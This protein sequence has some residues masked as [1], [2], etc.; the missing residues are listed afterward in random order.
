MP[1]Q[2]E[3]LSFPAGPEALRA[4][5]AAVAVAAPQAPM[6]PEP[7]A[8]PAPAPAGA[9]VVVPAAAP[10]ALAPRRIPVWPVEITPPAQEAAP[11]ETQGALVPTAVAVAAAREISARR[12]LAGMEWTS[13]QMPALAVAA[14]VAVG[15]VI[16]EMLVPAEITVVAAVAGGVMPHQLTEMAPMVYVSSL[17]FLEVAVKI[18]RIFLLRCLIFAPDSCENCASIR[19]ERRWCIQLQHSGLDYFIRRMVSG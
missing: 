7:P 16:S 1:P 13:H 9:A 18:C 8:V 6:E 17:I 12:E 11:A 3:Q 2:L 10:T 14:V 5:K 4:G 19:M 15:T